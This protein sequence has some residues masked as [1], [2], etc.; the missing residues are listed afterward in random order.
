MGNIK[1]GRK[2][3]YRQWKKDISIRI[4]TYMCIYIILYFLMFLLWAFQDAHT[5]III[6]WAPQS[7]KYPHDISLKLVAIEQPPSCA[8][9][10]HSCS[11]WWESDKRTRLPIT[12]LHKVFTS[13]TLSS[14]IDI[15]SSPPSA[16]YMCQ[17]IGTVLVQVMAFHLFRCNPMLGY[18]QWDTPG[19]NFS[20]ILIS[21]SIYKTFYSRKAFTNIIREMV[22]ILS[23]G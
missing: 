22:A 15:D 12:L 8:D 18:C 21:K 9:A 17:W 11:A 7:W 14:A 13:R 1:H 20:E 19:I 23:R 10:I 4:R 6:C 2:F 16:A 5:A 3:K